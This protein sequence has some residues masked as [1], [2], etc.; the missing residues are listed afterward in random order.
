MKSFIRAFLILLAFTVL[1]GLLYPAIITMIA[2][3][4]FPAQ[5][6]GSL[7]Y[8][9]G[10]PIGSSLI[11]QKFSDDSYF[12]SR[13]SA[14][15]YN[16]MPSGGS[17]LSP[18]SRSLRALVDT[19]RAAFRS[20]CG[21]GDGMTIPNDMLFASGSG[22]DPDISPAAARLQEGRIAKKRG[23]TNAQLTVLSGLVER[24]VLPPQL[25]FLGN[26]RVNV[27]RL[28]RDLGHIE[29]DYPIPGK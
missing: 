5:S 24:S 19:R 16:A 29:K 26:A 10:K 8:D 18:V 3:I 22:L 17:N 23:F 1:T 20:A 2:S 4:G 15:D 28:N 14:T 12:W 9:K 27:L 21:L 11:G 13:P 6:H 7:V 25:G